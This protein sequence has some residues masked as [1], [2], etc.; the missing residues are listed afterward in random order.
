MTIESLLTLSFV[1]M[2]L[3]QVPHLFPLICLLVHYHGSIYPHFSEIRDLLPL[4]I[5]VPRTKLLILL[6]WL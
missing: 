1:H 6:S 2:T 3:I 5:F 4:P